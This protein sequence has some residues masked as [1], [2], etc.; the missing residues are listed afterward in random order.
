MLAAIPNLGL[1]KDTK[2]IC[3]GEGEEGAV[4]P[5]YLLC[6]ACAGTRHETIRAGLGWAGRHQGGP[7]I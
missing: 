4:S 7:T 6:I 2:V 1:S 5:S 3:Q